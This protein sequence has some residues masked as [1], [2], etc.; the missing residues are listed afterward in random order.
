VEERLTAQLAELERRT[1]DQLVVVTTPDLRGESIDS[2]GLRLGNGWGIGRKDVDNGVLLIVAPNERQVRI[3]VGC[4]LEG[5]LTD[6]RAQSIIAETL[7]PRLSQGAY[8]GAAETG[9]AEIA[10]LLASEPKRPR[11]RAD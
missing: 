8:E 10:A 1:T 7:L 6:E 9:V 2:F 5:L 11:R 3:E 4:G